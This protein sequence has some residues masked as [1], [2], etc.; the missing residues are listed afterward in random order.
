MIIFALDGLFVAVWCLKSDG[1]NIGLFVFVVMTSW[2]IVA[3]KGRGRASGQ[4]GMQP[5]TAPEDF[6][7]AYIQR[8]WGALPPYS[9]SVVRTMFDTTL[10]EPLRVMANDMWNALRGRVELRRDGG[11]EDVSDKPPR[12]S[13]RVEAKPTS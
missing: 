10:E 13:R 5:E 1:D 8:F 3:S 6:T 11:P 4:A 2:K 7:N 9:G 12:K